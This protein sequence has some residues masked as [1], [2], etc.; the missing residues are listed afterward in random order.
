MKITKDHPLFPKFDALSCRLSPENL[1]CDGECSRAEVA[2][3]L[4]QIRREW[5]ALEK[6]FGGPVTEHEIESIFSIFIA[7]HR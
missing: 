4:M 3:R 2:D 6:Q 7:S 5:K 1:C